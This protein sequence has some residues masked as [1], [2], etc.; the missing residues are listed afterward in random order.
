MLETEHLILRQ[1]KESD[2]LPFI[3]M[4]KDPEVMKYFPKNLTEDESIKIIQTVTEI[5]NRNKWGI[6]AVELKENHKFIG[7]IGLH[8]QPLQFDFSPCV[9]IAWRL[10]KEYWGNGYATEGAKAVLQYAFNVLD[11]DKIV[12]FT[13]IT[14]KSSEA[15]MKKIGMTKVKEFNHPEFSLAP[16]LE[17]HIL[18]EVT[19]LD[20]A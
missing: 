8:D 16:H 10:A 13:A 20:L 1:W 6:W 11:L 4:G 14:N 12:S 18:Y 2:Y 15:V 7:F 19:K 9:E 3:N 5:L 17:K